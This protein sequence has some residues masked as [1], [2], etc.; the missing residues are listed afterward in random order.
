MADSVVYKTI[1]HILGFH[2]PRCLRY[3]SRRWYRTSWVSFWSCVKL[4]HSGT[5]SNP[6]QA[7]VGHQPLHLEVAKESSGNRVH[8][9]GLMQL[10]H[11]VIRMFQ[12]GRKPIL[13]SRLKRW[14]KNYFQRQYSSARRDSAIPLVA[15]STRF[16]PNVFAKNGWMRFPPIILS[17]LTSTFEGP[18][19]GLCADS[20]NPSCG[21]RFD[22]DTKSLLGNS[23]PRASSAA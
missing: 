16:G 15:R 22:G 6:Y 21:K 2:I 14:G 4:L 17:L 7:T 10:M 11:N 18:A 19:K 13:H 12:T 20:C 9:F 3:S 5:A 8:R 1:V 23:H